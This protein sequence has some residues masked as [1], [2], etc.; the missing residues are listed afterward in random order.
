MQPRE[1]END[2]SG[3]TLADLARV[4]NRLHQ[5]DTF[6]LAICVPSGIMLH[7]AFAVDLFAVGVKMGLEKVPLKRYRKTRAPMLL[8]KQSSL[9]HSSRQ[10]L[11]VDAILQGATHIL[12]VDSDQAFPPDTVHRLVRHDK[13]IVGANIVTKEIPARPCAVGLDGKYVYTDPQS[14]GLEQVAVLGTG[15][16]LI[17]TRVFGMIEPPLFLMPYLPET[18][19]YLG[20]DVYFSRKAREAGIPI[21]VDHDLSKLVGHIGQFQYFHD[22]VGEK[23]S[24]AVEELEAAVNLRPVTME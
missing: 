13:L 6:A 20:E 8:N 5:T 7:A 12:F 11:V 23:I 9:I 17:N 3:T 18:K 14:S 16:M 2:G 15:L 24:E 22:H 4:L 21:F 1:L 19:T 10:Q